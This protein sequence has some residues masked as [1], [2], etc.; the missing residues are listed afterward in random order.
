MNK[1][2][3]AKDNSTG[4]FHPMLFRP[5]PK[6]SEYDDLICRHYSYAHVTIG[7]D[8]EEEAKIDAENI[9]I[10]EDVKYVSTVMTF[11]SIGTDAKIC[12]META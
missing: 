8:S 1:V 7:F 6:P 3:V 5:T 12:Y 10:V 2:C 4:K 11:S 9:A